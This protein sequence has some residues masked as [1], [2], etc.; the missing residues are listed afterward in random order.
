L[1]GPGG[2]TVGLPRRQRDR[3]ILL[4]A[5][6]LQFG[7]GERLDEVSATARIGEFLSLSG[8]SW[9][10]DRASLR[11]ALIDE[12]FLEREASGADYRLSLRHCRRVVFEDGAPAVADILAPEPQA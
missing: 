12:G 2:L 3:W 9:G 10:I 11:R 6:A 5:V 1:L 8:I 7:P 4:R